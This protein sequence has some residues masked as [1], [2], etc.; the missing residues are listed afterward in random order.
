MSKSGFRHLGRHP[1]FQNFKTGDLETWKPWKII[2][3][4]VENS[5]KV[6]ELKNQR[7]IKGKSKEK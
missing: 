1:L 4:M 5:K 6:R 3:N 2:K 7:K